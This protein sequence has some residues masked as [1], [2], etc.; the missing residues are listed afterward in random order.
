[1]DS[2]YFWSLGPDSYKVIGLSKLKMDASIVLL[3]N[4]SITTTPQ[5]HFFAR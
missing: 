5:I 4:E 3:T 2:G 1:M